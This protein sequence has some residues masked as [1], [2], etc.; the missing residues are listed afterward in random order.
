MPY[1]SQYLSPTWSCYYFF[2]ELQDILSYIPS[3][4]GFDGG[5][6][7]SYWFLI[8]RCPT[9]IWYFGV[10]RSPSI[11]WLS[12]PHSWSFSQPYDL[13]FRM[14]G[15]LCFDLDLI[16]DH[17]SVVADLQIPSNHSRTIP[18]TIKYRKLQSINVEAF[19]ADIKNS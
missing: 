11:C 16:L 1:C 5:L 18:Q 7:Y 3:W 9:A 2:S 15:S 17:F 14:Q 12:Y 10:F 4:S 19:K 6:Q 13:F 8:I